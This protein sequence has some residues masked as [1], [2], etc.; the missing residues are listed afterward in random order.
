MSKPKFGRPSKRYVHPDE[1]KFEETPPQ[2]GERVLFRLN[3]YKRY[4]RGVWNAEEQ[5]V[6]I[7]DSDHKID[8]KCL[9]GWLPMSYG[10]D[11]S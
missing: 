3:G 2:D 6:I 5:V 9:M 11:R 4:G 8:K 1:R 7:D 10:G